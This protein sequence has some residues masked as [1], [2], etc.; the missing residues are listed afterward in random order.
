M[1]KVMILCLF[2]LSMGA[3]A[4]R[5][6]HQRKGH[7]QHHT[8]LT[9]EQHALIQSKK[10]TLALDLSDQQQEQLA[11]LLG[12]QMSRRQ[13]IRDEMKGRD[14]SDEQATPEARFERMNQRLDMQIAF[15]R[16]LQEILSESQFEQ[17]KNLKSRKHSA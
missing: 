9:A 13:A 3:T 15:Q 10:M 17:W 1:K 2:A 12:R 4:Q 6:P 8:E 5:S 7:P 11:S 14:D 16:E